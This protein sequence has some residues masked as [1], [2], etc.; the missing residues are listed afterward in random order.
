MTEQDARDALIAFINCEEHIDNT[1]LAG[2]TAIDSTE[3][4]IT[5]ETPNGDR[6]MLTIQQI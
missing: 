5:I 4:E 6:F 3:N 2:A 1:V